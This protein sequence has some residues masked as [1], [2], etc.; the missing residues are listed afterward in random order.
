MIASRH[1]PKD[2]S[3]TIVALPCAAEMWY[4]LAIIDYGGRTVRVTTEKPLSLQERVILRRSYPLQAYGLSIEQW[5]WVA[6]T[7][8]MTRRN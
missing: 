8:F 2:F 3:A 4:P 7:C 6:S 1:P 5:E